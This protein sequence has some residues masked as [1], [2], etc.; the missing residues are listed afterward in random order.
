MNFV[1]LMDT[2][3]ILP[4]LKTLSNFQTLKSSPKYLC[5][6]NDIVGS[7][8]KISSR[9]NYA[10]ELKILKEIRTS[11]EAGIKDMK[12]PN[13]CFVHFKKRSTHLNELKFLI[14]IYEELP[15]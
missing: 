14:K 7:V 1:N 4:I 12:E 9:T 5:E 3:A 15:K 13:F 8:K 11:W 2:I 10:Q 6:K